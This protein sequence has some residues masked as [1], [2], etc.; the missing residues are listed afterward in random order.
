MKQQYLTKLIITVREEK[1]TKTF[2]EKVLR[3]LCCCSLYYFQACF[4]LQNHLNYYLVT[5]TFF[6]S[7][8]QFK[9]FKKTHKFNRFSRKAMPY[10]Q[11]FDQTASNLIYCLSSMYLNCLCYK[12]CENALKVHDLSQY[13]SYFTEFVTT[14]NLRIGCVTYNKPSA[15]P[16]AFWR[17][18]IDFPSLKKLFQKCF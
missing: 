3:L 10:I 18:N 11:F 5:A 8:E 9:L 1:S 16:L 6:I 7:I 12:T 17:K 13:C 4:L 14:R 15:D 2:K